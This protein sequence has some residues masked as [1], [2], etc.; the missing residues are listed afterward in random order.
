MSFEKAIEQLVIQADGFVVR[1]VRR[2]DA[3]QIE[4]YVSDERVARGTTI[5]PHPL[6]PGA[7]EALI[8]RALAV[9]RDEDVWVIDVSDKQDEVLGAIMLKRLDREQ[10]EIGYWVAPQAWNNGLASKAVEA[11]I[12]ANPQACQTMFAAAFQDN[13]ASGRVLTNAGF[14]YIGDAESYSVSR[15]AVVPTWTYLK[16]M[17]L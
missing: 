10:S 13:P 4:M 1:P 15:D 16:K 3:G 11:V 12:A 9:D 5:I 7:T 2:S 14:D 8:E 17:T 6:P